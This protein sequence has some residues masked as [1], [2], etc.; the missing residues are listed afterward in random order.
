[1]AIPAALPAIGTLLQVGNGA[2]PEVFSSVANIGDLS[3]PSV[4]A[5]W[6]PTTSHTSASA[7]WT[8]GVPTLLDA[9]TISFPL[10]Y[11][12]ASGGP[13]GGQIGHN[14]AAGLGR[15]FANRGLTPGVPYNWKIVYP[16][17]SGTFHEFQ[18][19]LTKYSMKSPVAGVETAD[20]ELH[21]TGV[22]S[23]A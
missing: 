9:G 23:F 18:A 8:T 7:P 13:S 20:V 22:P 6:T 19:F 4:Q 17:G 5:T 12:P 11:I 14:F 2:S 3:G 16:D 21:V 15:L 10:Y 1:M